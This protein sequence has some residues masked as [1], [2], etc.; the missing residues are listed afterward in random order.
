MSDAPE[1][2]WLTRDGRFYLESEILNI[3]ESERRERFIE[4]Q[5]ADL[6]APKGFFDAVDSAVK[7]MREAAVVLSEHRGGWED[8]TREVI[9]GT[10]GKEREGWSAPAPPV[11]PDVATVER[12]TQ[13]I[14]D[15]EAAIIPLAK[16][17]DFYKPEVPHYVARL[18]AVYEAAKAY[19]V[20]YHNDLCCADSCGC[21]TTSDRGCNCGAQALI[22][23][24]AAARTEES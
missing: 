19:A 23:A 2:I 15:L 22:D 17:A 12:L 8:G 3:A 5:R 20:S 16:Q 24:I 18:E 9:K 11:A 10:V 13:R 21:M 6:A 14:H 4:Y 1:R 7:F